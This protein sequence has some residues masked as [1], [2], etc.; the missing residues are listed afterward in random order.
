MLTSTKYVNTFLFE[1]AASC[2]TIKHRQEETKLG[3]T[4][5]E[6]QIRNYPKLKRAYDL[7]KSFTGL[8][9]PWCWVDGDG[10]QSPLIFEP[11]LIKLDYCKCEHC[12]FAHL[13]PKEN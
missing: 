7:A 6:D 1:A 4:I 13:F 11:T 10:K 8:Y 5:P 9:C 12:G 3:I 2:A